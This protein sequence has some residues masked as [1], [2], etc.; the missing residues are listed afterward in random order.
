MRSLFFLLAS[1]FSLVSSCQ[2]KPKSELPEQKV[3]LNLALDPM[4]LDPRK[5]RALNE[6]FLIGMLF[7]GLA[8]ENAEGVNE[9]ALADR[10]EKLENGS[11]YVFHLREAYW[12]NG[13]RISSQDFIYAWKTALDPLFPSE[14]SY[15]LF[16]I[17]N[18]EAI[19]KG[20]M[21]S[22]ELGVTE[23]DALTLQIDLQYP[24]PY[25]FELLSF[26]IFFPVHKSMDFSKSELVSSGPFCLTT[27]KHN[28][29]IEVVKNEKYW[30]AQAVQLQ[31]IHFSMVSPETEIRMFEKKELD[32]AG[33]PLG[34]LPLDL[35]EKFR[36][37]SLLRTH[38]MLATTFFRL[39]TEKPPF[40]NANIRKAFALA[41][42]RKALTDHVFQGENEVATRFVPKS[43]RLQKEEYFPETDEAQ[44][45]EL[46]KKGLMELGMSQEEFPKITFLYRSSQKNNSIAQTIQQDWKRV[47][48]ITVELEANEWKVCLGRIQQ[49]DYQ[50]TLSDWIAD[51]NDPV[52]FLSVFKH[53]KDSLNNTQWENEEYVD[54]LDISEI[55]S[56]ENRKQI[57]QRCESIL[58]QEMPIIPLYHSSM[59]YLKHDGLRKV[60][61]SSLGNLDF[62]WAYVDNPK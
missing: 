17:K 62:K 48:G 44:A 60:V 33:S 15:Q 43:M 55:A 27:W 24:V 53:K 57:L 5:G 40:T 47:L 51:F 6:R 14:N 59:R 37:E 28:D 54:L 52:N 41:V 30:D 49:K 46:F 1:L 50:L 45:K 19:K 31:N 11:R 4:T 20:E 8:R 18:A 34:D 38:P 56:S 61:I 9:L 22:S 36:K 25:F 35:L 10:M 2:P 32:W 7:E 23:I 39:N 42:H 3:R 21:L 26:P 29:F 58:M 13:D 12:S 16:C